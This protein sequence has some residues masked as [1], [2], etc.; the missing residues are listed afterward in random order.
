MTWRRQSIKHLAEVSVSN[1]DKKSADSE[2]PVRLVNYTDVYYGDRL[3]PSINLMA[4]TASLAQVA[5]FRLRPGDVVITKDSETADD[6]G[7]A[8]FVEASAEDMVLGYHLALL[9]P[10]THEV[11]GRFL[12]W[13]MCSDDA[14]RQLA[15]GA[16]GVTRFGLRT[17]VIGTVDVSV[18]G[19][20]QQ[21]AIANFLD[22]ETS[23]IEALIT[24]KRR[25]IELS[26]DRHQTVVD[27]ILRELASKPH[28]ALGRFVTFFG[29]GV[30]PQA[31]EVPAEGDAW[32]LLKLSAVKRGRYLP[33]ENKALPADFLFGPEMVPR[34][35]DLLVTRSNTPA[36]VGDACVVDADARV[37]LPDLIY[38]IRLDNRLDSRFAALGL[39]CRDGRR[40]LSSLARGTSQSMV[41]LRGEDIR[42]VRIP[43]LPMAR[44]R[45]LV[46]IARRAEG[47]HKNLIHCLSRQVTLLQERRQALITA[48]VTGELEVPGAAA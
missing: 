14:R 20:S 2:L 47:R 29:Q 41:K 38:R 17:D 34:I 9:R 25:M 42:A 28:C 1:V 30:S 19:L 44:Q 16:T 48:A 15:S 13:A 22:T 33:A 36:Y 27:D 46:D 43:V 24:K 35:G 4:A 45:A 37:V 10:R 23:R 32:G 26:A 8:A 12:Y 18:P 3:S 39:L 5:A 11:D 31:S 40:H 6:I 7:I 21:R